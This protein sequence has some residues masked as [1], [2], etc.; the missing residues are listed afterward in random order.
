MSVRVYG[1]RIKDKRTGPLCKLR[2]KM[3]EQYA[4]EWA[5]KEGVPIEKIESSAEVRHPYTV[6]WGGSVPP[7]PGKDPKQN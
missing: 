4:A 5:A 7:A 1:W 2:W 6:G 3:T